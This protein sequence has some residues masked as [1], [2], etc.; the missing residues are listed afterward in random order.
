MLVK[1]VKVGGK[2]VK[3]CTPPLTGMSPRTSSYNNTNVI[4]DEVL[5]TSS[6][7]LG[8]DS[9]NVCAEDQLKAYRLKH[10]PHLAMSKSHATRKS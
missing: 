10:R 1:S 7:S 2:F 5:H 3:K 4:H 8:V 9:R 6:A